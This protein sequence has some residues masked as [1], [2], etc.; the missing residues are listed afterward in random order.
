MRVLLQLHLLRDRWYLVHRLEEANEVLLRI[1]PSSHDQ[2]L[3]LLL[4]RHTDAN[5]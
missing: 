5:Q 3:E 1:V 2:M 4:A